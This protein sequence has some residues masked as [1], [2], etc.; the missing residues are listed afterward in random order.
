MMENREKP[1]TRTR[2]RVLTALAATS[3][4]VPIVWACAWEPDNPVWAVRKPDYD[5][6]G[7][8]AMLSPSNDT[9]V[10]LALLLADRTAPPPGKMGPAP[11]FSWDDLADRIAPPGEDEQSGPFEG[12]RCQTSASGAEQ[13]AIAVAANAALSAPERD[14]LN[15]ARKG[16]SFNCA[17][18]GAPV[19]PALPLDAVKSPQGQQFG[20]YLRGAAAFYAGD[21]AAATTAFSGLADARD[22]WLHETAL[23]MVARSQLNLA[24][25]GAFDE[26]GGL[27]SPRKTDAAIV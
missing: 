14:A 8:S 9:R 13:F 5:G 10:N 27:A 3:L 24:Q 18:S 20:Q 11:L 2:N 12:S 4:A 1:M 25:K 15:A 21:F 7:A 6:N 16:F 22:G 26:W 23:Y 19:V 17:D